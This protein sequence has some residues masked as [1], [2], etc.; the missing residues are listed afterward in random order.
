M[1]ARAR[2]IVFWSAL[3]A[4]LTLVTWARIFVVDH[5]RDQGWF[6]K[7]YAFA[8]RILAGD[9]PH[10]RIGDVSPGYLWLTVLLRAL[11]VGL[12]GI[13]D[14]QI[15]ALTLAAVFC[16]AA[17]KRLGGWPAAI[18]A[19][20]LI[21]GNRAALVLATELEPETLILL[22][23][24]A[25]LLAVV[26]YRPEATARH[27]ALGLLIG[28]SVITRP[29]ALAALV[30]VCAWFFFVSRKSAF[31]I[32]GAALVPIV[33][34]LIVNA[35]LTG[36]L[37][38]MQPGAQFYE[39]NNPLASGC[40]GVLPRVIDDLGAASNEPDYLHVA[41]RLVAAR[42][43]GR[44]I[45]A[46]FANRYWSAKALAF[47]RLQPQAALD[48]FGWKAILSIHHYDIYDLVTTKLKANELSH[49]PA[50]P[51]GV[52]V[53]LSL[54]AFALRANRRA[55]IPVALFAVATFVALVLFN[56]SARQRNALLAPMA[57]LGG[58]GVA[59]LVALLRARTEQALIAFG[60]VMILTPLLGIEGAPMRE[61]AYDWSTYLGGVELR[62]AAF[63]ARARGER[64]RAVE[65][66]AAASLLDP[67]AP[68]LVSAP[69]LRRAALAAAATTDS[70]PRLFD[71]AIAL[72]KAG[73]W[74]EADAILATIPRYH[75]RRENRAVSSVAYY[76]ARAALHMNLPRHLI[77]Q[78]LDEAATQS[79]GDPTI[80]ALRSLTIDPPAITEL[81]AL[82]D[83]FTRDYALAQAQA[84][85]GHPAAAR[86]LLVA[87][88]TRLPEWRRPAATLREMAAR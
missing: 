55:V 67:L 73:A 9:I 37:F 61:N 70:P 57:V 15:V 66:A 13:R 80:L 68:P 30:L 88:A 26:S 42:A 43:T 72:E 59:Q 84:D 28:L 50:I 2:R 33:A 48:L 11:R 58:A 65:L 87:V 18:T 54:L 32:A 86:Q 25:A 38:I 4:V 74:R 23:T 46:R 19:A 44:A 39:A 27:A 36:H 10:D 24:S 71:L 16:A 53:V 49:Y 29:V 40:A 6:V 81:N 47:F 60:A 45:D 41:Y 12:H 83:P 63:A 78:L 31:V 51:F 82:H 34:V 7:Y 77:A 3:L 69:A 85:L 21:L 8:D 75:P 5:L 22:I 14:L 20:L 64:V 1:T 35:T 17:A 79:P 56:V 76:R 62:S 52:A